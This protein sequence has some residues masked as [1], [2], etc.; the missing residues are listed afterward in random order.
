MVPRDFCSILG[1]PKVEGAIAQCKRVQCLLGVVS[2]T[3]NVGGKLEDLL[4]DLVAAS[5]TARGW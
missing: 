1:L 4:V 2:L 5:W 3:L